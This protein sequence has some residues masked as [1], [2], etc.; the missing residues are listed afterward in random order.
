MK[1]EVMRL[2]IISILLVGVIST[3]YSYAQDIQKP[4]YRGTVIIEGSEVLA[5]AF[6]RIFEAAGYKVIVKNSEAQ[7]PKVAIK[8]EG[9]TTPPT[10]RIT[11]PPNGSYVSRT[12][13]LTI[14]SSDN[15]AVSKTILYIEGS[16][17]AAWSG[18]G[19]FTYN[20]DTTQY[21][22]GP[23]NVTVWANDTSGN[24]NSAYYRF[25][26]DNTPPTVTITYPT[27][28]QYIGTS[29][30]TIQWS[31]SDNYEIDHYEISIDNGPWINVGLNTSYTVTLSDGYH[32]ATVLVIDKAGNANFDMVTFTIDTQAPTVTITSPQTGA[33]F[34]IRNI[35]VYWTASD[36]LSGI[37]HYEVRIDGGS[38]INVGT[39]TSY[40]F[41]NLAEG[42]HTV[43]VKA[44][45]RAGNAQIASVQ[46]GVDL[47]PPTVTI[48]S[49]ASGSYIPSRDVT[50]TW[51]GSDGL[52]GIDHYEVRCTNSTWDSGWINAGTATS[53][54]FVNLSDGQYTIYVKAIDRAANAAVDYITITV[55]TTPPYVHID[56]PT[57]G[58]YVRGTVTIQVTWNDANPDKCEL[59]IDGTL[60]Y[61]WTTAGTVTYNWD[62]TQVAD[63][64][65][66]IEAKAYDKAGNTA[67]HSITVIVDNTL[68]TVHIDA[69]IDGAYVRG[70]T[71]IQVTWNDANPDK[72]ELYI[73]GTLK[74]TWTTT[75]TVTYSWDT[76]QVADGSHTI[77]AKAYDKAGNI[78]SHSITVIVDNTL[79]Y[80]HIDAPTDGAYIR[81]ITTIQVTWNDANPDRCELY[82]DGTL[83]YTWTTAGTV[84]YNWDTT[85]V[86]D[87]SHT[88]EAKAYDKA[89]N[90]ASH[91]I[92]A[93][94]DNTIPTVHI[95]APLDGAY[96]HGV[97][98]I[99]VTWSDTNPDKCELYID[100]VLK[101]TWTTTGTVTY[102]WDTTQVADGSH[103]I[104]ARAYDKAGNAASH[105][106][107]VIVD[108]TLP[109]V[110]ID[111]P[112][113]GAYV[114]GV[115][116][117]QVTW[118][119]A[120]PDKCELYIDGT[121]KYM[122]TTT[123]TVTYSWNT[124]QVAD[125]SHTIEAVAYDK[126]GNIASHSIIVIVDNTLPY[127]HIDAPLD[128]AYVRG[129]V[130]IQV[131]W[132]DANPDKCEL[133]ID[134]TL[135][136]TW[137]TTGTVTYSWDTTQ[138]TDG[139][140]TIEAV[141]YDKVG[142]TASHSITVIVDNTLPT[143]HIDA[144]LDGAYVRG[145]VAIQVTWNDANPDK[146]ELYI[147]GILTYTWTTTG[148]VTYD[149]DTTQVAD[150]PH[151]IEA[152]AYD[153]AG[154]TASHSITVIV[155]NTLPTVHIDAPLDGAYVRGTVTIQVTWNDANPDKCELYIDGTL[156]Y[157][158][159]TAGTVT[160]DWDSAQVTDGSHTIEAKAYDK[161]GNIASHSI[162][163]IVD[164]TLPYVHVD[165]PLDGAY[166]RG[167]VTIQVTWN[168]ANPDKCELY[169]DGVLTYTWTITGAVTYNWDTTRVADGPHTIEARA[170]DKAGNTASHSITVIVDNTLPYVHI[171]APTD[172][173]HVRGVVTI[174]VTWNDANP[175]KCELYIDD[176]LKYTWTITGTMTYNWD[177]TQVTDGSHTIE[178]RA[179]DKVGN[180]ASHSITVI[181]DNTLPTIVITSPSN[182]SVVS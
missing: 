22:D 12:T 58:A 151:T 149:W 97:V 74:Y 108:N 101:Y 134:G 50:V 129:I 155:D 148:A 45:D 152:R 110:H 102:N 66:T 136:Y 79:P 17:V 57:D 69:P 47:T 122:W 176:V 182:G 144:P 13:P 88:I 85:Q 55:D 131:T 137:T 175:D 76:T 109:T 157:T 52:S 77:E 1:G 98:T 154:N 123:G 145:I 70:I 39:S 29:T 106:I 138:V 18:G 166:V 28:D 168:D 64:S 115:T 135:K 94:V 93:T 127:V 116:T 51:T 38:W 117:I 26:V 32:N 60:K 49:P 164:N 87:G 132:S 23:K 147:D 113:D 178:A 33:W 54:T 19:T 44:V 91:S 56:A 72:C 130:T 2:F 81:G 90:I 112:L 141:A 46:F 143:V 128:G 181:V 179:Y 169:I 163:V 7:K 21:T 107:T 35:T 15:V 41:T 62:T 42:T 82:I 27:T 20:W 31:G 40:T 133:Y 111:A 67:S 83:K 3:A 180:T 103:T 30:I 140:H 84:T 71:T 125:G 10:V 167:T 172:G 59:Y 170:Y 121:L 153:K 159:T 4:R 61:T 142:N 158:W 78:A 9:D 150:G 96:V 68:P 53:Y 95:D 6:A 24:T 118:N 174:Q 171:D 14:E 16:M 86:I 165:A 48:T 104:E 80:V 139:S 146:C 100:G 173:T 5:I 63:G 37:D 177:T 114:R 156:K 34:N 161:A 162:T 8:Q 160:Y 120:N 89:G 105:S 65:H 11:T 126:A 99:Q 25:I 119:D 92:T 75:G 43:E 73:D 124:T 36:T